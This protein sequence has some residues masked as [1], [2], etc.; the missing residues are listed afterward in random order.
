M[1]KIDE[2]S[3]TQKNPGLV[4]SYKLYRVYY[5]LYNEQHEIKIMFFVM[6]FKFVFFIIFSVYFG[7]EWKFETRL[8]KH[9]L[10]IVSNLWK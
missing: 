7:E 9:D 5:T 8:K 10:K 4:S 6:R 3:S 1:V 2:I